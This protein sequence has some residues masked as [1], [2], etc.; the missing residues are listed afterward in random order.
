MSLKPILNLSFGRGVGC[1][2]L[3]MV[4]AVWLYARE[5]RSTHAAPQ[6]PAEAR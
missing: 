3:A 4:A 2:M 1:G 5:K 6:T